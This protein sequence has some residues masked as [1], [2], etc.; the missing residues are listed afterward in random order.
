MAAFFLLQSVSTFQRFAPEMISDPR[1]WLIGVIEIGMMV[2]TILVAILF[3]RKRPIAV[4][5]I[6]ALMAAAIFIS[7][8]QAILTAQVFGYL[9]F[10]ST[11]QTSIY[12]ALWIPYFLRSKRVKNTFVNGPVVTKASYQSLAIWIAV[13]CGVLLALVTDGRLR[14]TICLLTVLAVW[15]NSKWFWITVLMRGVFHHR[16]LGE[17]GTGARGHRKHHL[18]W[19][20]V[21][22]ILLLLLC[23]LIMSFVLSSCASSRVDELTASTRSSG[24]AAAPN[25]VDRP[26]LGL[27]HGFYGI[28]WTASPREISGLKETDRTR[29]SMRLWRELLGEL[30]K[31]HAEYELADASPLY[32]VA[33]RRV[34]LTFHKQRFYKAAM[35]ADSDEAY[36]LVRTGLASA[37]GP[38]E[39]IN[40]IK[41]CRVWRLQD[42]GRPAV[43]VF[44]TRSSKD[45][46]YLIISYEPVKEEVRDE[47]NQP[48]HPYGDCW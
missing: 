19:V 26:R 8:I 12:A 37:L 6:I 17:E 18:L 47:R 30:S 7:I 40:N 3:F 13:V 28:R 11:L 16:A 36:R 41:T 9:D 22:V 33:F 15:L 2:A 38:G 23:G 43:T 44:L 21:I 48:Y 35:S 24:E 31:N 27:R 20:S 14:V 46:V 10:A 32:S 1:L 5:A 25:V 45:E 39:M 34:T 29:R 4:P 42:S